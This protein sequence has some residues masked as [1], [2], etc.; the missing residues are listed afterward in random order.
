[1]ARHDPLLFPPR[2]RVGHPPV[3]IPSLERATHQIRDVHRVHRVSLDGLVA[4]L[5]RREHLPEES[6]AA[7]AVSRELRHQS[8][9]QIQ[10]V[11]LRRLRQRRR[12]GPAPG[13]GGQHP[14]GRTRG[15]RGAGAAAGSEIHAQPATRATGR[16]RGVRRG[17]RG[18]VKRQRRAPRF[19]PLE[20]RGR[21]RRRHHKTS[22]ARTRA[23][24]RR[25]GRARVGTRGTE[26]R[27]R[28]RKRLEGRLGQQRGRTP[29]PGHRHAAAGEIALPR[30][31][32]ARRR[33]DVVHLDVETR[34]GESSRRDGA[35][36][37]S[38]VGAESRAAFGVAN[39][40]RLELFVDAEASRV[41][42]QLA[43]APLSILQEATGGR[44]FETEEFTL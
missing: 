14:T 19:P 31:W 16:G 8:H 11:L 26:R 42:R 20:R 24:V 35:R 2:A 34:A 36:R 41:K 44:V 43:R 33:R 30:R 3:E 38:F 22:P 37:Q 12:G 28:L 21:Y 17:E 29:R 39:V 10:R 32:L 1:M 25:R 23:R 18:L 27:G 7:L 9:A 5:P 6:T 4:M 13:T 40:R 15:A